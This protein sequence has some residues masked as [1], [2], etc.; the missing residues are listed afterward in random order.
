M[1]TANS[2]NL[3]LTPGA[4]QKINEL[5]DNEGLRGQKELRVFVQGGGCAGMSYGMAFDEA[6]ETDD[7]ILDSG[8]VTVIVDMTSAAHL[9]GAEIDYIDGLMGQGF[10]FANPNAKGGCACGHSF[11]TDSSEV[12]SGGCSAGH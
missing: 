6:D 11:S 3:V 10:T 2:M 8:G 4:A 12:R 1:A 7:L 5:L 9:D